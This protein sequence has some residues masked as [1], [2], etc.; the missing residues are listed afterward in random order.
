[1]SGDYQIP[2]IALIAALMLA[3]AYLHLRF[4]SVRTLLWILALACA[5]L[6]AILAWV[7]TRSFPAYCI[8]GSAAPVWMTVVGESALM[9]SSVLFLGSLSPL[10]FRVR[11]R[12]VL[13]A[14]PYAIP[15]LAYSML[16]YGL[17]AQ[18]LGTES[19]HPFGPLL[20]IYCVLAIWATSIA[21]IWSSQKGPIPIWIATLLVVVSATIAVPFFQKGLVY[22]PMQVV[23]S[24][25]MLMTAL[26]VVFTYRRFSPGVVLTA[27]GFA[28]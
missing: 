23:E 26:L 6:R 17:P 9:L 14:F 10:S 22:W 21:F 3:F 4:R 24:G 5:E 28:V 2:A 19:H 18:F 7:P 25:N 15:L 11:G 12:H 20:W 27:C 16:Y 13:Y 1:M 8:G